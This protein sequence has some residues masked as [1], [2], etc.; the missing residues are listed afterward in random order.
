MVAR[1]G[2]VLRPRLGAGQLAPKLPGA[3]VAFGDLVFDVEFEF[4][5]ERYRMLVRSVACQLGKPPSAN[6]WVVV[7]VWE[8]KAIW[9]KFRD[10]TLLPAVQAGQSALPGPPKTTE[11]EVEVEL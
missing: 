3:G 6:G 5:R 7:A 9:E 4:E 10:Q 2:A 11:F 1:Q 8:S